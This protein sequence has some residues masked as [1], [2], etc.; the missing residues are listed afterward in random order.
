[1]KKTFFSIDA[2]RQNTLKQLLTI[3]KYYRYNIYFNMQNLKTITLTKEEALQYHHKYIKFKINKKD[4][5]DIS[6]M[7]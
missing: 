7:Y 5:V 2:H 3:S 6:S 1:M 4:F